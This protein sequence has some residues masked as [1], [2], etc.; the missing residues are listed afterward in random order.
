MSFL[1]LENPTL[2]TSQPQLS[3]HTSVSLK[4][5]ARSSSCHSSPFLA[6]PASFTP[7]FSSRSLQPLFVRTLT[8][9]PA[10]SSC[11]GELNQGSPQKLSKMTISPQL[12]LLWPLF[13]WAALL[14]SEIFSD[15]RKFS[16]T[17]GK[18]YRKLNLRP[19]S[20]RAKFPKIGNANLGKNF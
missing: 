17:R 14:N 11:Q 9:R 7:G 4:P 12:Y 10:V 3:S 8:T 16:A 15:N 6:L 19:D 1:E 2:M 20:V 18:N 5:T 13:S